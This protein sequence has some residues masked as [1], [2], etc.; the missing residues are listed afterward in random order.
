MILINIVQP[1]ILDES[2]IEKA[3]TYLQFL[4]EILGITKNDS[5]ASLMFAFLFNKMET[6][7]KQSFEARSSFHKNDKLLFKDRLLTQSLS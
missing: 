4:I 5:L 6:I 3:R 7:K 1:L 2:Q